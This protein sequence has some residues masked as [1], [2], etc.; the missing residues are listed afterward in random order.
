VYA[1]AAFGSEQFRPMTT[2][3]LAPV[4]AVT[5]WHVG[6]GFTVSETVAVFDVPLALVAR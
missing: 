6:G 5:F 3:T 2:G 4:E 1:I